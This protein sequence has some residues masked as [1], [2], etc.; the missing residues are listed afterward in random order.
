MRADRT[1]L[2]VEDD[3]E[4]LDVARKSLG[5]YGYGVIACNSSVEA[6]EQCRAQFERVDVLVVD[7]VSPQMSGIELSRRIRPLV[8][9]LRNVWMSRY[10]Q[11]NLHSERDLGVTFVR[12][13]FSPETLLHGVRQ[14][15]A[16]SQEV[17][18]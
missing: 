8:P 11:D 1:V 2:F 17:G 5:H 10:A 14:A 18:T 12:K 16:P 7:M 3:A 13:P 4:A 6:L 9:N 15:L